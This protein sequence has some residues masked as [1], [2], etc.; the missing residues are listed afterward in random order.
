MTIA[1]FAH[2]S[3]RR[4]S[5][6]AAFSLALALPALAHAR[7]YG[8]RH[9]TTNTRL[10]DDQFGSIV[11]D[12]DRIELD[13]AGHQVH[14]SSYT[15]PNCLAGGKCGIVLA[16]HSA[17]H[18]QSCNVVGE[19]DAGID[20]YAAESAY[21]FGNSV[22]VGSGIGIL[23]HESTGLIAQRTTLSAGG[24]GL[25]LYGSSDSYFDGLAIDTANV[26][27]ESDDNTG[28]EFEHLNVVNSFQGFVTRNGY[29]ELVDESAFENNGSA[30]LF[31][32]TQQVMVIHNTVSDSVSYG[33]SL[34]AV[35]GAEI[36]ENQIMTSGTC[37]ATMKTSTNTTWRL[38][39]FTRSC[40][41]VPRQH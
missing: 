16:N 3:V 10:T 39:T 2:A 12:A 11:I 36:S 24:Y 17:V 6:L 30:L 19:F 22:T 38:N 18:I 13:C 41:D 35:D 8:E 31:I 28:S 40:G 23:V 5:V 15:R 20:V 21:L 33:L 14:I 1:P 37:D 9:I 32:D 27:I 25:F 26:G 4:L 29:G 7:V 34:T